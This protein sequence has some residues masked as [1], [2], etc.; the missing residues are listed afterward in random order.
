MRTSLD[1]N[2]YEAPK[3]L[4]RKSEPVSAEIVPEHE[5]PMYSIEIS[6]AEYTPLTNYDPLYIE[7]K[8]I[9]GNVRPNHYVWVSSDKGSAA[10]TIVR[11]ITRGTAKLE[12]F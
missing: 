10:R 5:I 2:P 12:R 9:E 3:G 4:A 6:A 7:V 8:R 1:G 11:E